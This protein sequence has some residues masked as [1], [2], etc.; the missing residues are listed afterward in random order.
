MNVWR[1]LNPYVVREQSPDGVTWYG[2]GGRVYRFTFRWQ[3]A[4]VARQLTEH[5]AAA[6]RDAGRRMFYFTVAARYTGV[7][8]KLTAAQRRAYGRSARLLTRDG[9]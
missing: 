3:A 2:Y 7:D 5:Y 4:R 1:T 8:V 6:N 9:R